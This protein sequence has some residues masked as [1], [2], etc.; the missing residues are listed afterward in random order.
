MSGTMEVDSPAPLFKNLPSDLKLQLLEQRTFRSGA[1]FVRYRVN[2][3]G[4]SATTG[5]GRSA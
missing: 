5:P 3:D 4:V 1:V 2:A